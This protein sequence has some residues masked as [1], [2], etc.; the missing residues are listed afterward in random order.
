MT[1]SHFTL[2]NW[3][4]I[5]RDKWPIFSFLNPLWL[6]SKKKKKKYLKKSLYLAKQLYCYMDMYARF[7]LIMAWYFCNWDVNLLQDFLSAKWQVKREHIHNKINM[8]FIKHFKNIIIHKKPVSHPW[9]RCV[10]LISHCVQ[11]PISQNA[12]LLM[13][14][15][16]H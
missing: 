12:E 10:S 11:H 8:Q 1:K 7:V 16:H 5:R 14:N 13:V 4:Q 9:D 3:N 6:V 2:C 15:W